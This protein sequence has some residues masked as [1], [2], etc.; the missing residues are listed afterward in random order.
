MLNKL[1]NLVLNFK[2]KLLKNIGGKID[3]LYNKITHFLLKYK[4]L[5][6]WDREVKENYLPKPMTCM[7]F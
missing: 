1:I 2:L 4:Y 6:N 5:E 3:T 7:N